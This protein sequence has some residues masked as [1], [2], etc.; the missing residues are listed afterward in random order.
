M[1]STLGAILP[2]AKPPCRAVLWSREQIAVDASSVISGVFFQF[3]NKI[4]QFHFERSTNPQQGRHCDR[5][6]RFD[7]LPMASGKSKADH[8]F[9]RILARFAQLSDSVP[10]RPEKP[11]FVY[12]GPSFKI[13]LANVPRAD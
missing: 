12:H 11:S 7:L 13:S 3:T 6:T 4:V 5:T 9:L 8:I 2:A 1:G 10:Q